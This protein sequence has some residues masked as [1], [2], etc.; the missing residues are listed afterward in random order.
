MRRIP[1]TIAAFV[2]WSSLSV[3]WS[4]YPFET[5]M[6]SALMS[7]TSIAGVLIA[8]AFPPRELLDILTR[9]LQWMIGL[10][11]GLELYVALV[12]QERLA[13]LYMRE[14]EHIPDSYYWIHGLLLEGGPIQ[15]VFANRN[16]L[17]FGAA[18]LLLCIVF[19]HLQQ[20]SS[21]RRTALWAGMS[22]GTLALTRSATVMVCLAAC[23]VVMSVGLS[24]RSVPSAQRRHVLRGVGIVV[25]AC[26]LLAVIYS[27]PIFGLLGRSSDMTG[28]GVIW[29][30]L[31]ALW[32]ER[33]ILG[34][35][36]IPRRP[37]QPH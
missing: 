25:L 3:I 27:D 13:P 18:L 20:R 2:L 37:G 15:G 26:A 9:S 6:A 30:R 23:M 11:L 35:G 33:P 14:W 8:V 21:W 19:Q 24:L 16:P 4:F 34:W 36:W 7:A 29:E 5:I 31:L 12:L 28:R 1:T 22:L 10:S 17:A 32:S